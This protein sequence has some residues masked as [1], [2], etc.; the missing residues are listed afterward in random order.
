MDSRGTRR[1]GTLL[2]SAAAAAALT[3]AT[4]G[5]AGAEKLAGTV[6]SYCTSKAT[7]CSA[8]TK[9]KGNYV[10]VFVTKQSSQISMKIC[11]DAPG[12]GKQHCEKAKQTIDAGNG[13]HGVGVPLSKY[14]HRRSG[15]Y[16]VSFRD[17]GDR[18]GPLLHFR[19]K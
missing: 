4:A 12:R 5:Q 14:P 6:D 19:L 10:F 1:V 7:K 9:S 18:F 13:Y 11:L 15:K 3:C 16:A 2:A 8:I 17:E